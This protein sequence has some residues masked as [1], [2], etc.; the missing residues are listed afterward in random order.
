[1]LHH[2]L[3][4]ESK[5]ASTTQVT[6]LHITVIAGVDWCF[7][8]EGAWAL[9]LQHL[10]RLLELLLRVLGWR[11][12]LVVGDHTT[13]IKHY[14]LGVLLLR[15]LV[16]IVLMHYS[17]LDVRWV[18]AL[19]VNTGLERWLLLSVHEVSISTWMLLRR[20]LLLYLMNLRAWADAR[21]VTT[22]ILYI[23]DVISLLTGMTVMRM[24]IVYLG[25]HLPSVR[26]LLILANHHLFWYLWMLVHHAS[27]LAS[28]RHI[29]THCKLGLWLHLHWVTRPRSI[30]VEAWLCELLSL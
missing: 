7:V 2:C 9:T 26:L 27:S 5:G 15:W 25:W 10:L 8:V 29:L 28:Y 16:M 3:T 24:L 22:D 11:G 18:T 23:G 17:W 30:L 19:V 14:V 1:M 6:T 21:W 4:S 20:L 13:T 12:S